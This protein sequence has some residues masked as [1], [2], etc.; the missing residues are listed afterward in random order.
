[1]VRSVLPDFETSS[2]ARGAVDWWRL[3]PFL[4]GP[5]HPRVDALMRLG[6]ELFQPHGKVRPGPDRAVVLLVWTAPYKRHGW[7]RR[8]SIPARVDGVHGEGIGEGRADL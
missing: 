3:I 7:Q 5:G 1:M 8:H 6:P 4:V 2:G